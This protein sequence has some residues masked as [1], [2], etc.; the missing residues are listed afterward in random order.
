MKTTS[1]N[2]RRKSS[3]FGAIAALL[4]LVALTGA[5]P[6]RAA[7]AGASITQRVVRAIS[8]ARVSDLDFGTASSGD[9]AKTEIPA[10][11]L[12]VTVRKPG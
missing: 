11:F 4:A 6:A 7:T 9:P 12:R 2:G 1:V 10:A 5:R 8:V 3:A